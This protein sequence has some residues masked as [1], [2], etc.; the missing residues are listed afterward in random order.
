MIWT[1][2]ATTRLSHPWRGCLFWCRRL[3]CCRRFGGRHLGGRRR[4]RRLGGLLGDRLLD[5]YVRVAFVPVH[6]IGSDD[7]GEHDAAQYDRK[8]RPAALIVVCHL[9]NLL[10]V[11]G[12][13]IAT[14]NLSRIEPV[15][16]S[17]LVER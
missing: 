11:G 6:E 3:W 13:R 9:M 16:E 14:L 7:E 12:V 17:R 10:P 15:V 4:C 5:L 2:L 1:C 8:K